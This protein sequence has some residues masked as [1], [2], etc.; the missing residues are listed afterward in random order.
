M[1]RLATEALRSYERMDLPDLIALARKDGYAE[2][3][4][5][6][7]YSVSVTCLLDDPTSET[8]VRILASVNRRAG[9]L[10]FMFPRTKSVLITRP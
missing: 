1:D 9:V 5:E 2:V 6:G 10:S 4:S 8:A 3:R 7:D